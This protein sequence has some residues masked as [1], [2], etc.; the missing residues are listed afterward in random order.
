MRD[1]SIGKDVD[2]WLKIQ[3]GKMSVV[4]TSALVAAAQEA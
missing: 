2:E 3:A 4:S 1:E